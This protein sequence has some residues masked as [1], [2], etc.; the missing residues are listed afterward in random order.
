MRVCDS[1][2]LGRRDQTLV[3]DTRTMPPAI[4]SIAAFYK[5]RTAHCPRGLGM[6]LVARNGLMR[7]PLQRLQQN[8]LQPPVLHLSGFLLGVQH[9]F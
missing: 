2:W 7:Q 3:T 6:W 1:I 4:R 8:L 5:Q 9:Q